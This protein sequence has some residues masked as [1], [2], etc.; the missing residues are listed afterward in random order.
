MSDTSVNKNCLTSR[1]T[2]NILANVTAMFVARGGGGG[3]MGLLKIMSYVASLLGP[4]SLYSKKRFLNGG[5]SN[6]FCFCQQMY[7]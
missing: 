7:T 4:K 6:R 5:I 2:I 3:G 1:K